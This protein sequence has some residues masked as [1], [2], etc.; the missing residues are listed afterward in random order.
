MH[1][2][3]VL[4]CYA[5]SLTGLD[6]ECIIVYVRRACVHKCIVYYTYLWKKAIFSFSRDGSAW[7]RR[8]TRRP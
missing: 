1:D 3:F 2:L 7:R 5:L 6:V 8:V 4:M